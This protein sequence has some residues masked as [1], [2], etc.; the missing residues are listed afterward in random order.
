MK[1]VTRDISAYTPKAG[2]IP[3]PQLLLERLNALPKND[4]SN[5]FQHLRL[6]LQSRITGLDDRD[7]LKLQGKLDYLNEFENFF[8]DLLK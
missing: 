4:M 5:L 2:E 7:L 1:H 6:D 8:L 3:V